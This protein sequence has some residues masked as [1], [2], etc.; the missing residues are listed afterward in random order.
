[1]AFKMRAHWFSNQFSE[2]ELDEIILLCSNGLL[3]AVRE[4][5]LR[6][7]FMFKLKEVAYSQALYYKNT[8]YNANDWIEYPEDTD[9]TLDLAWLVQYS[10]PRPAAGC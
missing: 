5:D 7:Y 2:K 3:A 10:I 4:N 1:M 9:H 8:G 6:A